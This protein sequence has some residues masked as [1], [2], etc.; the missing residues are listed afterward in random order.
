[1]VIATRRY[2]TEPEGEGDEIVL[3]IERPFQDESGYFRCV[4]RFTGALRT[5][6]WAAGADE[7]DSLM[8]ALSMAGPL[9]NDSLPPIEDHW[10]FAK[11]GE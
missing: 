6:R 4:Y 3:S 11:R 7:L 5:D 10:P 9:T 8:S 2:Y 1:M